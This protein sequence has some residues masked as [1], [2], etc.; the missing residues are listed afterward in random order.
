MITLNSWEG[1]TRQEPTLSRLASSAHAQRVSHLS[2][3]TCVSGSRTGPPS[4]PPGVF[5]APDAG[6]SQSESVCQAKHRSSSIRGTN[7]AECLVISPT[8][9]QR[10]SVTS[11]NQH[12]NHNLS[13]LW[14]S[15][16]NLLELTVLFVQKF[17]IWMILFLGF[18]TQSSPVLLLCISICLII[19]RSGPNIRT[20]GRWRVLKYR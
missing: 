8:V 18:S 11:L 19:M 10:N 17:N 20:C 7:I 12:S 6:D 15:A 4:R 5:S 1:R 13:H 14:P 16:F 3:I 9:R 2:G